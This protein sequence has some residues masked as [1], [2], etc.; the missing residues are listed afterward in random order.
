LIYESKRRLKKIWSGIFL[1]I[2]SSDSNALKIAGRVW[3]GD[4]KSVQFCPSLLTA[5]HLLT[6]Q[7]N[8][9]V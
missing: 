6:D 2:K 8:R 5:S 3:Q 4:F 7:H 1:K 9:A